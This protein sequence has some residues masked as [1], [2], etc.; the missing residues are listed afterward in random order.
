M[1]Q[2]TRKGA[3][4]VDLIPLDI[5]E[6]LNR[7]EIET[8]NLIEGLAIDQIALMR[9]VLT[10]LGREAYIQP[11]VEAIEALPK[12]TFNTLNHAIGRTLHRLISHHRDDAL[13]QSIATHSSDTIRCWACYVV[14]SRDLAM[15]EYLEQIRPFATDHHFGVREISW[16]SMRSH[17]IEHLDLSLA[18]LSDWATDDSPYIRRFATEA[19]RPRGVWCQHIDRLKANPSL[20]SGLL[21]PLKSEPVRYVQDSVANWLNDASKTAPDF[22][23]SLIHRWQTESPTNATAYIAKR[24]LRSLNKKN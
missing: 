17:I 11:I 8:A 14:A 1:K 19:T 12:A 7:G 16:L 24:A 9:S 10:S 4:R 3:V 22:V 6:Q 13:W 21:E 20:A 5:L 15:A 18:L 2:A 23:I